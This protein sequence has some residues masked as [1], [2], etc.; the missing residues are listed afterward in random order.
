M[1][2][3][4]LFVL[5]FWSAMGLASIVSKERV[6]LDSLVFEMAMREEIHRRV[7]KVCRRLPLCLQIIGDILAQK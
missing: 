2:L 7:E 3:L 4:F 6:M 1:V 5:P